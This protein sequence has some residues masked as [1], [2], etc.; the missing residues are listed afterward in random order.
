[1]ARGRGRDGVRGV[2]VAQFSMTR[3]VEVGDETIYVVRENGNGE[4]ILSLVAGKGAV[5]RRTTVRLTLKQAVRLARALTGIAC[6][7]DEQ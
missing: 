1:M 2:A 6:I 7:P 5:T 4:V 3:S